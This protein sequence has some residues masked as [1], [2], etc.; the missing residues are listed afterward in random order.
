MRSTRFTDWF[1]TVI[2]AILTLP[3][4]GQDKPLWLYI[5]IPAS[6][7]FTCMMFDHKPSCS[8]PLFS[9]ITFF[10]SWITF[11]WISRS[12][13]QSFLTSLGIGVMMNALK[14][15]SMSIWIFVIVLGT[16]LSFSQWIGKVQAIVTF[17]IVV[18]SILWIKVRVNKKILIFFLIFSSLT[19]FVLLNFR[20]SPM[21]YVLKLFPKG[22]PQKEL[23]TVQIEPAEKHNAKIEQTQKSASMDLGSILEKIFF[24]I[25]LILFGIFLFTLSFKM[26]KVKGTL[27]LLTLGAVSFSLIMSV[28]S[29]VFSLIKPQMDSS[30]VQKIEVESVQQN[31]QQ[32]VQFVES[33]PTA[34]SESKRNVI[35]IA[36]FLNW[37]SLVLLILSGFFMIYLTFYITTNVRAPVES[38]K[39]MHTGVNE[40]TSH[41][42]L[43]K[44]EVS[45]H[46]VKEAYW[47]L[48]RKYF[49]NLHHLTPYE[50]LNLKDPFEAFKR[51]TDVY[52]TLKYAGKKL[53]SEEIQNFYTDFLETCNFLEKDL[54][55][56]ST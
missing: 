26:F 18:F 34:T 47:W 55:Q 35:G 10:S 42:S 24:P 31:S 39:P 3:M 17:L 50:V 22:T 53:R 46:F 30:L 40:V 44:C 51:L 54:P 28:L 19:S 33:T 52:V 56:R 5:A 9:L 23:V 16:C 6:V 49:P 12:S 21:Q 8:K 7:F 41:E 11:Y 43:L 1:L 4:L 27:V 38:K 13:L 37:S 15:R 25:M 36:N 32:N 29:L 20:F 48:R 14:S 45:E 2:C